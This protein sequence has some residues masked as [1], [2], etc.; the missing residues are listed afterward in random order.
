MAKIT[1]EFIDECVVCSE[2]YDE[3]HGCECSGWK[4]QKPLT[5]YKLSYPDVFGGKWLFAGTTISQVV[6][7]LENELSGDFG[8]DAIKLEPFVITQAGIDNMPEFE[9]W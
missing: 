1:V 6:I 8:Q 9:G 4:G 5:G 2:K 7:S 3:R